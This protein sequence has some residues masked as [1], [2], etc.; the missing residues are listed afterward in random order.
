MQEVKESE[1]KTDNPE[2]ADG[3][4]LACQG[5]KQEEEETGDSQWLDDKPL[6]YRWF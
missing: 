2:E 1:V 5:Q 4:T 6:H 3:S